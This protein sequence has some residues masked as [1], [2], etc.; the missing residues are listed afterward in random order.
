MRPQ[1]HSLNLVVLFLAITLSVLLLADHAM[2]TGPQEHTLYTYAGLSHGGAPFEMDG[3]IAD[4]AGN[5]YGTAEQGGDKGCGVVF[6]LSPPSAPGSPWTETVLYNFQN[7]LDGYYPMGGLALDTA[8]NLYGATAY[9]NGTGNGSVFELSPPTVAGGPWTET[10]I[11]QFQNGTDGSVP[12][13]GV[14]L[15][16]K[17]NLYGTT[18]YGGSE[19][20]GTVFEMSPPAVL[21]GSW[22][23]TI[24]HTFT[25]TP[26]S[27]PG[28]ANPNGGLL[29]N[30]QGALFGTTVSGG[31]STF[32]GVVFKLVPP[33]PGLLN[34]REQVLYSFTEGS[35]GAN[36]TGDLAL[37]PNG[38]FFGV[39]SQPGGFNGFGY[40]TVYKMTPPAVEGGSWTETT[41]YTF[42]GGGSDAV[43]VSVMSHG[44]NLYGTT[45]GQYNFNGE[46]FELSLKD[47]IWQ[48][49]ILHSF[50]GTD[51]TYPVARL[52]YSNGGFFGTTLSG[53]RLNSGVFF[54]V[55]P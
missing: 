10:T 16:S 20:H 32:S 41:I 45:G 28:G 14:I 53:G 27:Y 6:E 48:E 39:T 1:K 35:D 37:G 54:E 19:N 43:P 55:I 12:V 23:E 52:A 31:G 22:T 25:G 3:L 2:A 8:G 42:T 40:G 4:K 15:D 30:S 46:I 49:T 26:A 13:S 9:G 36:P 21:G 24:L 38:S 51:G 11:H 7:G 44:G 29:L 17:G 33:A 47:G 34:W 5:L 50:A 18:Y